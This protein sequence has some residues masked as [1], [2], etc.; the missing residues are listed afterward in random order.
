MPRI[1]KLPISGNSVPT[2]ENERAVSTRK[3]KGTT[4]NRASGKRTTMQMTNAA[5]RPT[6]RIGN[7]ASVTPKRSNRMEIAAGIE[8]LGRPELC[9]T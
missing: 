3:C 1:E 9:P 8:C 7:T 5:E 4:N 2:G 6:A